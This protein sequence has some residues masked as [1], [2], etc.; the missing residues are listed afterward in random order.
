[1]NTTT[2][3]KRTVKANPREVFAED[4]SDPNGIDAEPGDCQKRGPYRGELADRLAFACPGCAQWGSIAC[5]KPGE[6]D[7]HPAAGSGPRWQITKGELAD[8]T[9]LTLSPSIHCVGCCGWHGYL[10]D[11]VFRSC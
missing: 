2:D 10:T 7:A 9:T 5:V 3:P 1:M 8:P 4:G 6:V 11:G